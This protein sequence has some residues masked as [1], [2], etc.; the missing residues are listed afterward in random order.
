VRRKV[1]S[2]KAAGKNNMAGEVPE[3]DKMAADV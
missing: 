1:K 2:N 3:D